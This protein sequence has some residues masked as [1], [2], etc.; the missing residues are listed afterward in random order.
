MADKRRWLRKLLAPVV[1]GAAILPCQP[2]PSVTLRQ[3][4]TG[5]TSPVELVNAGDGSDKLFVVQQAGQIKVLQRQSTTWTI[6]SP[7]FINIP[8]TSGGE[9]GLL[10]LA[11]HPDYA[12]NRAFYV[13]YTCLTGQPLP[14]PSLGAL[15]VARFLRDAANPNRADPTTGVVILSI[16]HEDA[17]NHNGGR[18]AF[19]PDGNLYIGTGDGSPGGD[20]QRYSQNRCVRLGKLLRIAVDGGTGYTIPPD[21]PYAGSSCEAGQGPQIWPY[22]LAHA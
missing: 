14:C 17:D 1:F 10:G 2:A 9:R 8:V 15:T 20:Q 13:F 16:P 3:V 18:I 11:F 7:D 22:G 19:G 4:V 21:N 12:S 6:L 5:L